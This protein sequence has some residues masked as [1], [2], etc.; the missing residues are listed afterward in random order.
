M[1]RRRTLGAV[2]HTLAPKATFRLLH[3]AYQ[4][5]PDST[6]AAGDGSG[7]DTTPEALLLAK[8]LRGVYW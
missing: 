4:V 6:A 3:L 5:F 1:T 7:Q 8:I 2:A